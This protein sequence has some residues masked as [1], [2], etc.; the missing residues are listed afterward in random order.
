MAWTGINRRKNG[1]EKQPDQYDEEIPPPDGSI[2][3]AKDSATAGDTG[4]MDSALSG[5]TTSTKDS[6]ASAKL[7]KA[8][9]SRSKSVLAGR[10]VFV[11][12]LIVVAVILAMLTYYYLDEGE[13]HLIES[14]YSS[15]TERALDLTRSLATNKLQH[16]TMVMAQVAAYSFPD[17]SSWPYVWIDGYWDI[18]GNVLPTSCYTGIHLAP[19]VQPDQSEEFETFAYGKFAETFGENTTMGAYS[20]FGK[21]IW[22]NRYHDTTGVSIHGSPYEL[23]VPKLQHALVDS[24]Y[25]MMNV[26]G[27]RRQGEA[28]DAVINCTKFER[29][30]NPEAN[31]QAVSAFNPPKMHS[32]AGPFGFIATPIFPANDPDTLVGFIFGA[33]FWNEVMEEIFPEDVTGIDCVFSTEDEFYTYTIIEGSGHWIGTGDLHD[34]KYDKFRM[35][36]LLLDPETMAQGSAVYNTVCYPNDDFVAIYATQQPLYLAL[37]AIF[38]IAFVSILFFTYDRCVRHEFDT[39][40]DLLEAKRAFVRFVSHEVRTPL[41]SVSMGLT[42]M[43]EELA[44]SLGHKSAE[45]MLATMNPNA[46]VS[47]SGNLKEE[48][49][50][51]WFNLAHEI[52]TSAQSSVDVLNDLLNYDK[53]ENNSLALETT[54][55]PIW[56]LIDRTVGEFKLPISSKNIDLHFTLPLSESIRDQ[57]VIGDTVRI[58]QVLR[59]LC[60]NAIKFTPEGGDILVNASWEKVESNQKARTFTLKNQNKVTRQIT[61][62]LVITVKDTGAGMTKDQLKQLFGKGIQFNVNELQHGNGSGLGLYIA[63]GIVE[64]HGGSMSCD[65]EGLGKGTTFTM[66]LPLFDIPSAL[67]VS[68]REAAS[69]EESEDDDCDISYEDSKLKILIVDDAVSNRKLLARLLKIKG[70]ET[71][72]A[73]DGQVA[74]DMVAEAEAKGDPYDLVLMDYE[75]PIMNGPTAAQNIR[76]RNGSDVF[77]IGVTGNLMPED[78]SYFRQCGSNAVLPKPFRMPALEEIIIEHHITRH[79]AANHQITCS[80]RDDGE[81]ELVLSMR[82]GD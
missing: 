71:A 58:T 51:E 24:L 74:V 73:E 82:S 60:S 34:E 35:E 81:P 8:A 32:Q 21:G 6:E 27:F 25:V 28:L 30:G 64:Q 36:R 46:K 13:Q 1:Q 2:L 33:V 42:V 53:I 19:I 17:A 59:N 75:M 7:R 50:K 20:H 77:I 38:I 72:Q 40:K 37:A 3:N 26:H 80:T 67:D 44:Q 52:H 79:K 63:K 15:M 45:D 9:T 69:R 61:G 70:H 23:L 16:G 49:S 31:C 39:K 62:N 12:F 29:P 57:N 76:R 10:S 56:N 78:V 43:K 11:F 47:S 66:K 54:I 41:N 55:V 4:R 14:Q 22:D 5:S 18:V 68:R 65:S 48:S